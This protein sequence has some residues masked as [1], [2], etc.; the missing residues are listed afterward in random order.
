MKNGKPKKEEPMEVEESSGNVFADL[1]LDNAEELLARAKVIGKIHDIILR[2]RLTDKVAATRMGIP[3][4]DVK[5]IL[6]G[7]VED[8]YSRKELRHLLSTLQKV[9]NGSKD[10]ERMKSKTTS[11][12]R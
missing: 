6:R 11:A 4:A 9:T 1:G 3:L 5:T 7:D 8:R 10:N 2:D 12:K